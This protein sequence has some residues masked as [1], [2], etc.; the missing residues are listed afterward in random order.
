MITTS[1]EFDQAIYS[2]SRR[3]S[4][5]VTFDISDVT[6][7]D[8]ASVT[9]TSEAEISRKD[10]M[11]NQ[12]RDR[13]A[14]ATFEPDYWR[15]DGS[16]VLPPK[17]TEPGFEVGWYSGVLSGSDGTFSPAQVMDFIFD[18]PHSSI[19]LTITFDEP[20]G[21]YA[22]DFD[23][24]AYDGAGN[25]IWSKQ[26]RGNDRARWVIDNQQIANYRRITI[27]LLKWCKPYRRA[28][29][30]EV[31][32]GVVRVYGDDNLFRVNLLEEIDPISAQVP[33]N[34]LK[35]VVDNSN[36]EFNILNPQGSYKFL[37][38]RQAAVV[39]FGVEVRPNTYEWVNMGLYFLADWKSDEGSLTATFTA[40]NRIDFL[41][42][43]E[44]ENL[45]PGSTNLHELALSLINAIGLE[46]YRLDP[47]LASAS[48][49]GVY[50]KQ[51]YRELLQNIAVA[52]RCVMFVGRDD[53][54]NILRLSD[55]PPAHTIELDQMYA[56]PQINLDRLVS[57][58]EVNY[59]SDAETVA[60]TYVANGP[61]AG[62][63]TLKVEN[64][65]INSQA[66]AQA[67]AEWILAE[68]QNRALYEVNWR[69]NPALEPGDIVTVEDV[70]GANKSSRIISQEF[71]YGGALQGKTKSKGA[72]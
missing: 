55:T 63:A 62:G 67:V 69:Q 14:Y 1:P 11:H 15:L 64:T 56:E 20:A 29:V 54:F 68:S 33:A 13:P 31:S 39:E 48:T 5:R 23:A 8:D 24:V 30:T 51:T 28:K 72:I 32:F 53:F 60:G 12:V 36:R 57:R 27:T 66:H 7:A 34:E 58:V 25:V 26:V 18:D 22:V 65:L 47:A 46:K 49:L 71:E 38:E 2:P 41:P 70:Y 9:V 44:V 42:A 19:G 45:T 16:F 37:Q 59:Y 61:V 6:A 21:E 4:A 35:F 40:R 43:V 17:T 3:T 50:K 10:Q 52:G